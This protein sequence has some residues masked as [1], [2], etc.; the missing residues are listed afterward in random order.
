MGLVH[1][2]LGAPPRPATVERASILNAVG[3]VTVLV[4]FIDAAS[5]GRPSRKAV[6]KPSEELADGR[7]AG[8]RMSRISERRIARE[9]RVTMILPPPATRG[10]YPRAGGLREEVA[11]VIWT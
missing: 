11:R 8:V 7:L 10:T 1:Q 9:R 5:D 3:A 6:E 2:P 4:V